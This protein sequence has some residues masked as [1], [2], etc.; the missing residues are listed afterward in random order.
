MAYTIINT[1]YMCRTEKPVRLYRRPNDIKPTTSIMPEGLTFYT[2]GE[3]TIGTVTF[4]RISTI[5]DGDINNSN[6]KGLWIPTDSVQMMLIETE[7]EI[8]ENTTFDDSKATN[9]CLLISGSNVVI[10]EKADSSTPIAGTLAIGDLVVTD[11]VVNVVMNGIQQTRYRIATVFDSDKISKTELQGNWILFNYSIKVGD[12]DVIFD[13][14]EVRSVG[15]RVVRTATYPYPD[16]AQRSITVD[17]T[18]NGN[19]SYSDLIIDDGVTIYPNAAG[20][21]STTAQSATSNMKETASQQPRSSE[22]AESISRNAVEMEELYN[23]YGYSYGISETTM[24][25]PIGRL[26][27][28]HGMP[29][30]YTHITDRRAYSTAQYGASSY[31]PTGPVGNNGSGA[32]EN[33]DF[34]GRTFAKEVAAN[35]PIVVVVPGRPNFLT[36]VKQGLFGMSSQNKSL[37]EGWIPLWSDLTDTESSAV[38]TNLQQSANSDDV[39]QYYSFVINTK[40]Y[41]EYVNAL[42]QTAAR[43]MGLGDVE[44]M[45]QKCTSFDWGK[46]NQATDQDYST[47]DEV[48]GQDN[49][50]SFAFDPLSSITDSLS[51]SIGSSQ[52]SGMLNEVSQ[53]ARELDF[54]GGSAG[55]SLDMIDQT[56]YDTATAQMNSG[57]FSGVSNPISHLKTFLSNAGHGM[58]VRFP[59]IWND[60]TSSK[61][62]S[63][64]MKFIAPYSTPF[65]KWRYVLVPFLHWFALAAPHSDDSLVNYSRP[66]LVRAFSKG[67]FNVEM[68]IISS[69][70]WRRFGDGDMISADGIPTEID[71]TVDFEDLYQQIAISRFS[72]NLL[73]DMTRAGIFFNNTGLMDLIGTLSGVN[74]NKIDIGKRME[75]YTTAWA[76]TM[77]RVGTNFMRNMHDRLANV[78]NDLIFGM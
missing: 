51:N 68:G 12:S 10:Y 18:A 77:S 4:L 13:N 55:V 48:V 34:Y 23:Q 72:G 32:S 3:I 25:T 44:Y 71:V 11:R 70:Q 58:N 37:T 52:F 43:L 1:S 47:F 65:C 42:T 5:C 24:G 74:M 2:D 14:R 76:G 22:Q 50:I 67:Y 46:Y 62:Y 20:A 9:E 35:M 17:N 16:D 36:L 78:A 27:F 69:I 29:F 38:L 49:G 60:S 28:V 30:Q 19:I 53:K 39:Y 57:M 61:S 64:D 7:E 56:D 15:R 6:A 54:I 8:V 31:P 59:Q 73:A 66:F 33:A 63:I 41:Y 21:V 75:L 45:G 26:L 40:D